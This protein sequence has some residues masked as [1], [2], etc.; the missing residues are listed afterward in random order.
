MAVVTVVVMVCMLFK[1]LGSEKGFEP[2]PEHVEGR[3][4]SGDQ[5]YEPEQFSNWV[6]AGEGSEENLIL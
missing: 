4:T 1:T 6:I 5:A 3:H 2:E